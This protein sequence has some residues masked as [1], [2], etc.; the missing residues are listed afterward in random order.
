MII[1]QPI[2]F[3]GG[4]GG[5]GKSTTAAG[6]AQ[7]SA[8]MGNKTLLVSTD[9]AHNLGDIFNRQL[10]GEPINV[11]NN[12][13]VVEIDSQ[14]ET[15]SYIKQVKQNLDG[16]VKANFVHEVHRQLDLA[17]VSPGAEEA[18][19]FDKIVSI[20]LEERQL[21]DRIIFDTAPT[22]HTIRLLTLPEMM[23]I[24]IEGMLEKR[25]K[26][27]RK[28]TEL[29]NDGEAIDDPIYEILLLR[30]HRFK[31]V[32]KILLDPKLTSFV[33]VLNPE[34]LPILETKKAVKMLEEHQLRVSTIVINKVLPADTNSSFLLARKDMER[35]YLRE[36]D[37]VFAGK[38]LI[39]IPLLAS[40]IRNDKDLEKFSNY[41]YKGEEIT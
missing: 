38:K 36:I 30:K 27:N 35:Q 40:D 3:V 17:K 26:T 5:V 8:L 1:N 2:I 20:I 37:A 24:W 28:Y 19:L 15:E 39:N 6:L 4:K 25:R 10:G 12:L 23:G 29:L 33:F 13:A 41:F 21:Y 32:R 16:M 22:G 31:Q 14:K 7:Q 11:A 9:P 18:A 34:R